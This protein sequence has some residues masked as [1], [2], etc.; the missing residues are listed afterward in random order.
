MYCALLEIYIILADLNAQEQLRWINVVL[1]TLDSHS[2]SFENVMT[3]IS[4]LLKALNQGMSIL[5]N[6]TEYFVCA[7]VM[8]FLSDMSQQ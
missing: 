5:I 8:I 3:F 1:L 4:S 2:V 7:F 6:D